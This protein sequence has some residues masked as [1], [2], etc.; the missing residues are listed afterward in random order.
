MLE[1]VSQPLLEQFD[2]R[3]EVVV[4]AHQQVDVVDVAAATEAV[5]QVVAPRRG[6]CF[7]ERLRQAREAD[8]WGNMS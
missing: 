4:E 8:A 1:V 6:S 5:G 2:G 7:E 3:E